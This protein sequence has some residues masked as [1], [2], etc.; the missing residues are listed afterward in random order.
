MIPF[1][2]LVGMACVIAVFST[3]KADRAA[4]DER[5]RRWN[6]PAAALAALIWA[7]LLIR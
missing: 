5:L 6:A 2:M 7:C 4:A 1:L 3:T